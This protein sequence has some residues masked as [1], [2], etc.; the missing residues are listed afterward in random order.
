MACMNN[1]QANC[2]AAYKALD[3]SPASIIADMSGIIATA[4]AF[5]IATYGLGKALTQNKSKPPKKGTGKTWAEATSYILPLIIQTNVNEKK[6]SIPFAE[7]MQT[8]LPNILSPALEQS[9]TN[10]I[11]FFQEQAVITEIEA[12][13]LA[14][15]A[16]AAIA[17]DIELSTAIIVLA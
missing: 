12:V 1:A 8:Y 4:I 7:S 3:I 16:S 14:A 6:V 15:E 5:A 10:Q 13:A 2:I 9:A 17:F 11:A